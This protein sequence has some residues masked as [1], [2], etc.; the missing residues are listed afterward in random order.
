MAKSFLISMALLTAVGCTKTKSIDSVSSSTPA[1]QTD[2]SLSS[3]TPSVP[4]APVAGVNPAL[5]IYGNSVL[6]SVGLLGLGGQLF[7]VNVDPLTKD[8]DIG[9]KLPAPILFLAQTFLL[10]YQ[11]I[12]TSI[13]NDETGAAILHLK[14]PF[15]KV[16]DAYKKWKAKQD[17]QASNPV[18]DPEIPGITNP[19]TPVAPVVTNPTSLKGHYSGQIEPPPHEIRIE[20]RNRN[21]ANQGIALT[22]DDSID[23]P[24][25][26]GGGVDGGIYLAGAFQ[27]DVDANGNI[28]TG[29]FIIHGYSF[30]VS[31]GHMRP[32][33]SFEID[34]S[35]LP[36]RGRW[37]GTSFDYTPT[38][39]TESA[40]GSKALEPG[41]ESV[42]GDMVGTFT[43]IP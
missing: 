32:D 37:N 43:P 39:A 14:V 25:T 11:D 18:A 7:N 40:R 12:Q 8:F 16:L 13:T 17:T 19:T 41:N 22:G 24:K 30:P 38:Y 4:V 34:A 29:E 33:G 21:L 6:D 35:L 9:L 2:S 5:K 1:E 28:T 31:S 26:G 15:T 10:K 36:V 3:E 20:N 27:F 42:Y 23:N